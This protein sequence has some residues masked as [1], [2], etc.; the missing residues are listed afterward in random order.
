MKELKKY[1]FYKKGT[2][3][4]LVFLVSITALLGIS[5]SY[6]IYWLV[7]ITT[8]GDFML[9]IYVGIGTVFYI[10]I[11]TYLQYIM[12]KTIHKYSNLIA[13]ILRQDVFYNI[14]STDSETFNKYTSA[15][16]LTMLR[17]DIEIIGEHHFE[18]SWYVLSQLLQI[19]FGIIYG[20][21]FNYIVTLVMIVLAFFIIIVP[22]LFQK[23]ISKERF[24]FHE[25]RKELSKHIDNTL[26]GTN[27]VRNCEAVH[28]IVKTIKEYDKKFLKQNKKFRFV[29]YFSSSSTKFLTYIFEFLTVFVAS[30]LIYY[31]MSTISIAVAF[32]SLSSMFFYPLENIVRMFSLVISVKDTVI[33]ILSFKIDK[34]INHST[35][36]KNPSISVQNL[37]IGFED[38]V[39][40]NDM[41]YTFEFGKKYLVT[42]D[43]GIG[44]SSLL[45]VMMGY[46][47]QLEGSV[48]FAGDVTVDKENA[49]T[50]SLIGYV[51]Q[52]PFLFIGS[53]KENI[54]LFNKN[55]DA[56]KLTNVIK[57]CKLD[58]LVKERG[59][60]IELDNNTNTISLGEMQRICLARILYLDRPI[61]FFDEITSSLDS[62]NT[63]Y[64]YDVIKAIKNKLIVWISH[65]E[66]AKHLNWLDKKIRIANEKLFEVEVDAS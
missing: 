65:E 59:L 41:S 34:N 2:F 31:D 55:V 20:F 19:A 37:K 13:D 24:K 1:Y 36:I 48:S 53:L 14:L 44:K 64:I 26:N 42:G 4:L 47:K 56:E 29:F 3:F 8:N 38:R 16:Y 5:L 6:L 25:S 66:E 18:Y 15:E 43:S 40:I 22:K 57:L 46:N 9:L 51:S 33:K 10:V 32:L 39:L 49:N 27:I 12:S 60:D 17:Q 61:L 58:N 45:N 21:F 62:Q 23:K 28:R 63:N 35:I 50:N 52:K 7:E 30:I 11:L 54:T